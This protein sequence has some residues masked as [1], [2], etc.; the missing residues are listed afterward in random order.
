MVKVLTTVIVSAGAL[1][2]AAWIFDGIRIT[3]ED[4]TERVVTLLVVAA[5]FG[6]INAFIAPVVKLLSLPFIILTLGLALIVINA[7]MLLLATWI[8]EQVDLGF[9]VDGFWT[10]VGGAI[11]VSLVTAALNLVLGAD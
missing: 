8:A 1:A 3:G 5:I 4:D 10:A 6:A 2:V 7:C 9:V 11:I